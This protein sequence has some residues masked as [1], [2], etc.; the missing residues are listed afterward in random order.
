MVTSGE[1]VAPDR[2]RKHDRSCRAADTTE[3]VRPGQPEEP[4]YA[5]GTEELSALVLSA[6][7]KVGRKALAEFL[8]VSQSACW[9]FERNRIHPEELEAL[10]ARMAEVD[11]LPVPGPKASAATKAELTHRIE[12]VIDLLG[13]SRGDRKVSKTDLI[14]AALAVLMP[15]DAPLAS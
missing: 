5:E 4:R 15:A 1:T 12:V 6:R 13:K 8:G 14:D 11:Q 10:K 2:R 9:R 7:E 3:V